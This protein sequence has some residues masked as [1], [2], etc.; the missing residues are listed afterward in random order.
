MLNS[1]LVLVAVHVCSCGPDTPQG[2]CLPV[3]VDGQCAKYAN[4]HARSFKRMMDR[5]VLLCVLGDSSST[6]PGAG[7]VLG[8]PWE[9]TC[10][11]GLSRS[12]YGSYAFHKCA[13]KPGTCRALQL[14]LWPLAQVGVV[15]T[16]LTGWVGALNPLD[17]AD[18]S[19]SCWKTLRRVHLPSCSLDTASAVAGHCQPRS[20]G[21]CA[22]E[23]SALTRT[24]KAKTTTMQPT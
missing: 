7:T 17:V 2:S 21:A 10:W 14:L 3:V 6:V 22:H 4:R 5:S 11:S 1:G 19:Q 13:L 16:I 9:G 24:A 20:P 8:E 15:Y 18:A 12:W 23:S